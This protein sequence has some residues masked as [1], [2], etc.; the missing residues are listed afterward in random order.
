MKTVF[1]ILG[2][3]VLLGLVAAGGFWGGMTYQSNRVDQARANFEAARGQINRGQFP[4][5]VPGF[6]QGGLPGGQGAG[7]F[8]G[9]GT[10]GQVKT[11]EGNVMT[12]STPQDVITVNLSDSTQIEK[13]VAGTIADLEPGTRVLVAGERDADG[14]ITASRITI[15]NNNR[16]GS[17]QPGTQGTEP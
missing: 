15:L 9:R 12:I 1:M 6:P 14:N 5:D 10:T 11:V 8:G 7:F 2:G 3:I 13:S 16:P 17:D 4:G